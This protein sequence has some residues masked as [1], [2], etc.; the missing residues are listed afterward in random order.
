MNIEVLERWSYRAALLFTLVAAARFG[1]TLTQLNAQS[2][3]DTKLQRLA[4]RANHPSPTESALAELQA[5][6]LPTHDPSALASA[7]AAAVGTAP[8]ALPSDRPVNLPR[9]IVTSYLSVQAGPARSE[10]R[11]NGTLLGKTP[12]LGQVSCERGEAVKVDVLPPKGLPR[13]YEIP[14]LPGEMR[15]R[16]EP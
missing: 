9:E 15:L 3:V 7:I 10:L 1:W 13:H 8:M 2:S 12:F 6:G 14:C 4:V 16:E 5:T 11:V